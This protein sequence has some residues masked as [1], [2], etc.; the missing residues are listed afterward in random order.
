MLKSGSALNEF[1][2]IEKLGNGAFG[3]V[4]LAENQVAVGDDPKTVALKIPLNQ[5]VGVL[6][7]GQNLAS[8]DH[9]N[10]VKFYRPG[11]TNDGLIFLVMEYMPGGSLFRRL[12][13]KGKLTED[14]AVN[15]A[16][17]VLE[18]LKYLH[19]R[20]YLHRDIKPHN[21]LFDADG[22][23]RLA[24]FG[25]SKLL[26]SNTYLNSVVGTPNYMAPEVWKGKTCISSDLWSVGIVLY[27]MLTGELPFQAS[28]PEHLMFK[29]LSDPPTISPDLC[30]EMKEITLKTLEKDVQNRY[31]VASVMINALESLGHLETRLLAIDSSVRREGELFR[32]QIQIEAENQ[33]SR[34]AEFGGV[35]IN[36][37]TVDYKEL[38][39]ETKVEVWSTGAAPP[40]WRWP[41]DTIFGFRDDHSF[42][43]ITAKC[44][45]VESVISSWRPKDRILLKTAL[46]TPVNRLEVHVRTW[47]T[48]KKMDGTEKTEGDP[49]WNIV[50]A[51]GVTID[52]QGIP[53]YFLSIGFT[54]LEK[55]RKEFM[56]ELPEPNKKILDGSKIF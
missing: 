21:I 44:L 48:W 47:A 5:D 42:G 18:A 20:G 6:S 30:D 15:I 28:N 36:V 34:E 51:P 24:D 54:Y 55:G 26:E 43:E 3:Q 2:L 40:F 14:E 8:L 50:G 56:V 10:I 45:L 1:L 11:R 29:I 49:G 32:F 16:L 19:G 33:G 35:T 39:E 46:T 27:E 17:Q 23:T 52:Q 53:A 13:Y 25:L 38:F 9:P 41:G 4:W 31:S 22:N 12:R 7:E 37:P